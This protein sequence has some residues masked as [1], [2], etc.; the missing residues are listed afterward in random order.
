MAATNPA[1][2]LQDETSCPI[3][4]EYFKDP[5]VLDCDHNF[6]KAC[7]SQCW[8]GSQTL[9]CPQCRQTCPEKNLR[10]NRQ[11]RNI[12]EPLRYS[13]LGVL[14]RERPTFLSL[15][16]CGIFQSYGH[17]FSSPPAHPRPKQA[18]V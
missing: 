16:T 17:H 1:K 9:S 14:G 6:C 7:I 5:V 4:L 13:G 11:L 12:V 3:C 2:T 8:E 18:T 10:P 15:P